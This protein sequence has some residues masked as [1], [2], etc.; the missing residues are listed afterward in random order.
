MLEFLFTTWW[1][2]EPNSG[3]LFSSIYHWFNL[4]EGV[5]WC[6]L[7]ALVLR[8]YLRYGRTPLEPVYAFSFLAFGATDFFEAYRLP[9]WLIALK[10]VILLALVIERRHLLRHHYPMSRS[11]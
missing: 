9:T 4:V 5:L 10:A 6:L 3:E 7:A 8:R 1:T 2:Y 11:Y